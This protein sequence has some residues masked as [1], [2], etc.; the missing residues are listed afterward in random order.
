MKKKL[1]WTQKYHFYST[2]LSVIFVRVSPAEA[3]V[4]QDT[5]SKSDG[6]IKAGHITKEN[7]HI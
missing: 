7:F 3:A 6:K 1:L 2:F 5:V 4:A